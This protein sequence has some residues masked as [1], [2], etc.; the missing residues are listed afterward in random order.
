MTDEELNQRFAHLADA[1]SRVADAGS[2]GMRDLKQ[3]VERL[4][5]LQLTSQNQFGNLAQVVLALREEGRQMQQRQI[6]MEERQIQLEER[7]IQLEERQAESD[8]RFE[9]I[10]QEIRYLIRHQHGSDTSANE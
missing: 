2:S 10:L 8:Q 5:D 3:T 1:I 7:Q 6:Q 9:I 4:V